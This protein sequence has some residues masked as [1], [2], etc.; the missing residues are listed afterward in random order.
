VDFTCQFAS[1]VVPLFKVTNVTCFVGV[2]G[3][4]ALIIIMDVVESHLCVLGS[5]VK[6][7]CN[8][9]MY[10]CMCYRLGLCLMIWIYTTIWS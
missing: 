4:I 10:V 1:C 8:L 3:Q 6:N 9:C 5:C 7:I 2:L